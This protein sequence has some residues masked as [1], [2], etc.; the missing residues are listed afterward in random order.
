M[1][2]SDDLIMLNLFVVVL[3]FMELHAYFYFQIWEAI[4]H[5]IFK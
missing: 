4:F 3:G 1:C 5:Y 2:L